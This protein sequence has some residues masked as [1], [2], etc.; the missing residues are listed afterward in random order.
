MSWF[1]NFREGRVRDEGW[2][3]RWSRPHNHIAGLV[4]QF[5]L[6]GRAE[7]LKPLQCRF[8]L[9]NLRSLRCLGE[10]NDEA[11]A[12]AIDRPIV[13]NV[14]QK[15]VGLH[16]FGICEAATTHQ[17]RLRARRRKFRSPV[18]RAAFR[19]V[20]HLNEFWR[21]GPDT[22]LGRTSLPGGSLVLPVIL[23]AIC[24]EF[25]P[26]GV[27]CRGSLAS[28]N[29]RKI[30]SPHDVCPYDVNLQASSDVLGLIFHSCLRFSR[31]AAFHRN[32]P[33]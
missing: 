21:G 15:N 18:E 8:R 11:A 25:N 10:R 3:G 7:S 4:F 22:V 13:M 19:A 32:C 5:P 24:V 28:T 17:D 9:L 33:H 23:R 31:R 29:R 26:T 12:F 27:G 6:T 1:T 20:S 16:D 2:R 30:Y 14:L